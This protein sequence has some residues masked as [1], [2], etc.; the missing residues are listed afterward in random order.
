MF[1]V[2]V[3]RGNPLVA[4][5]LMLCANGTFLSAGETGGAKP[6][7]GVRIGDGDGHGEYR[8]ERYFKPGSNASL[9]WETEALSPEACLA[10]ENPVLLYMYDGTTKNV[11]HTARYFEKNILEDD[12]VAKAFETFTCLM[13][14]I[15]SHQWPET[16]RTRA[17]DGAVLA[18][19]TCDGQ[20]VN[21]WQKDFRPTRTEVTRA[22]QATVAANNALLEARQKLS[23]EAAARKERNDR[24]DARA[25]EANPAPAKEKDKEA[26]APEPEPEKRP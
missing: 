2:L 20:V 13:L 5:A 21:L 3:P 18:L 15:T 17:R 8:A 4:V 1:S 7:V 11:N 22:A 16:F 25:K 26:N 10:R 19:L 24:E 23:A 9:D 14:P 12:E 6:P